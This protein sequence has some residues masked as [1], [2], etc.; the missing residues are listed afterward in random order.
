[1]TVLVAPKPAVMQRVAQAK[2]Q[3]EK[4]RQQAE[5]E[6]RVVPADA[7]S[8]SDVEAEL[9]EREEAEDAEDDEEDAAAAAQA[10]AKS[11]PS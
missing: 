3:A 7:E 10:D 9:K 2:L 11:K 6:G 1:M 5:K 4:L 8:L